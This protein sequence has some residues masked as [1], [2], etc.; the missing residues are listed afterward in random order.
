MIRFRAKLLRKPLSRQTLE[1]CFDSMSKM[2]GKAQI[3]VVG[4]AIMVMMGMKPNTADVD[5]VSRPEPGV[6][7]AAQRVGESLGLD[8][9]WLNFDGAGF[10]AHE[11]PKEHLRKVWEG[12]GLTV[13]GPSPEF[14]FYMKAQAG[15]RVWK[16][17]E[18]C[19][20][21][22]SS[23]G[24]TTQQ[25][26]TTFKQLSGGRPIP[27]SVFYHLQHGLTK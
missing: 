12:N 11:V 7:Q 5:V 15:D 26:E 23:L 25:A 2:V 10:E 20:A 13:L 3:V 24:W 8:A 16:A 18:D 9:H 17:Q 21:I 1:R 19:L 27:Q 22:A 4:G 6:A 14:L